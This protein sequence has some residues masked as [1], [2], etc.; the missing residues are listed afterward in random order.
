MSS[1][2]L[3]AKRYLDES[4]FY[5]EK[6]IRITISRKSFSQIRNDLN[7]AGINA[8]TIFPELEGL[9]TYLQWR[10]FDE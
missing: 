1:D 10:Y 3:K 4:D 9:C 6:L 2:D 8:F 7:T 5:K